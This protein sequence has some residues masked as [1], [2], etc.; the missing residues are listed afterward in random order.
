MRSAFQRRIVE[1]LKAKA[2]ETQHEHIFI[3][4]PMH[5]VVAKSAF[6]QAAHI[7]AGLRI[8]GDED[9]GVS[10]EAFD[11]L[12]E[13][14]CSMFLAILRLAGPGLETKDWGL[15]NLFKA[16]RAHVSILIEERG[17]AE[18]KVEE[19]KRWLGDGC[20]GETLE[21]MGNMRVRIRQLEREL[22]EAKRGTAAQQFQADM[23]LVA[24]MHGRD[25]EWRHG[26]YDPDN[27]QWVNSPADNDGEHRVL[28][29]CT[30]TGKQLH[31][32]VCGEPQFMTPSGATCANGHGGAPGVVKD[33]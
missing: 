30:V 1:M 20:D 17:G 21:E 28:A 4:G 5:G 32:T 14:A 33:V 25:N 7:V 11:V 31:C 29:V 24:E 26:D 12:N 18:A 2:K 19:W 13:R 16:T 9:L 15:N 6:E 23:A 27:N 10:K 8:L 22:E 3:G